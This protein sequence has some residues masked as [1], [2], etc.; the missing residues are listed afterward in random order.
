[1]TRRPAKIRSPREFARKLVSSVIALG[2]T[3]SALG[4]LADHVVKAVGTARDFEQCVCEFLS[5]RISGGA[6][7]DA[8]VT[9]AELEQ[10]LAQETQRWRQKTLDQHRQALSL[11]F[12]VT[13]PAF[14]A[15]IPTFT[16]GRAYTVAEIE[17][18]ARRQ[19]ERHRLG[20]QL[21]F[22]SGL[23][24]SE[25]IELREARELDPEPNRPWRSDLFRGLP[26]GVIYRTTGKG[27]LARSV[28]ISLE[29]HEQLQL[30][31]LETPISVI[32]RRV[33]RKRVFDV[34]G[35]HNLSE[36]FSASSKREL[37]FSMG[38]HGLRHGYA[39]RRLETLFAMGLAP[40]DC[41][42]IVSQELGHLRHEITLAYTPRRKTHAN[43]R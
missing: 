8:P 9:R 34:G 13:L 10:Y 24:A 16:M 25:L 5:W 43:S 3:T 7:I 39:Q 14:D 32:D 40:L 42:E 11:V 12:C 2:Q 29:L 4:A 37:G 27:G 33:H 22:G 28:W 26:A 17:R 30:R 6:A 41:L 20:T 36:S 35:G 23:R 38:L 31:R 18:I 1:M 19:S 21:A 15:E